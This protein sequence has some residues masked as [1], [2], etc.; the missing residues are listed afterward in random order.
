MKKIFLSASLN[1]VTV[2]LFGWALVAF[3]DGYM[4]FA[5]IMKDPE[6]PWEVSV[7]MLPLLLLLVVCLPISI[8][9]LLEGKENIKVCGRHSCFHLNLKNQTKENKC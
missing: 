1:I 4:Q 5:D 3:Y 9:L 8:Y 2:L 6:P 7:N